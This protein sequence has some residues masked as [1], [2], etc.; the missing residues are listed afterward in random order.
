MAYIISYLPREY[1]IEGI[2]IP[3]KGYSAEQLAMGKREAVTVTDA[4]L[5]ALKN[6]SLFSYFLTEKKMR[7]LDKAP[8]ALLSGEERMAMLVK[9]NAE[10]KA[11]AKKK[12]KKVVE[13]E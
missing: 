2:F 13:E 3:R 10:L 4:Q 9:E 8:T 5:A 1:V 12:T 6:N 11:A 7:I